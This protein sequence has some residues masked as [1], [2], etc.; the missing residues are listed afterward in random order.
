MEPDEEPPGTKILLDGLTA[1]GCVGIAPKGEVSD[2]PKSGLVGID[3][4]PGGAVGMAPKGVDPGV[5]KSGAEAVPEGAVAP[6]TIGAVELPKAVV[7][8]V[9]ATGAAATVCGAALFVFSS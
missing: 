4:K 9:A 5:P 6:K 1:A 2:V 3:P 7:G 8:G